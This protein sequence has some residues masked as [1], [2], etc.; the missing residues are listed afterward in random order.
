VGGY[1]DPSYQFAL[2]WELLL[3]FQTAQAIFKRLPR[4]LGAFRVHPA[5]K[6]AVLAAIGQQ[7]AAWLH[8]QYHG[9]PVEWLEIRY[10]VRKY[11]MRTAWRYAL[12]Y[13]LHNP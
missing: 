9:R 10:H 1:V 5:Q 11:L 2:D 3:R 6:T 8:T 13:I 12:F 4:F 7:E